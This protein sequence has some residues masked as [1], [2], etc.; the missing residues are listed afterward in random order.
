[1]TG[2]VALADLEGRWRLSRRIVHADGTEDRLDGTTLF[3]RDGSRLIQ[4][5]EGVL[6]LAQGALLRATRRYLWTGRPDRLEVG[7]EDG[8][9]FHTVPLGVAR[10]EASH[11]CPPDRYEVAYDVADMTEW[12]AVWRVSGPGKA[13]VMTSVLRPDPDACPPRGRVP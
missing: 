6:R 7:F 2:L 10:P 1:M 5:E 13:Y 3:R 12:R 9:P 11:L 8:R 4:E